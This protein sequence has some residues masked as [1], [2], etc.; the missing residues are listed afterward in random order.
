[1][2]VQRQMKDDEPLMIAWRNYQISPEYMNTVSHLKSPMFDA[3]S[4]KLTFPHLIG[5]LWAIFMAGWKAGGGEID[6]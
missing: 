4:G 5:A 3:Q 2:S 6:P 1:M